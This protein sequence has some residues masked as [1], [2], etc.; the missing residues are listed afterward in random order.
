MV[1]FKVFDIRVTS[2]Q[3]QY[4]FFI[5]GPHYEPDA[6]YCPQLTAIVKQIYC[7]A[8]VYVCTCLP[9][10]TYT[11]DKTICDSLYSVQVLPKCTASKAFLGYNN[12]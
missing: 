2:L 3:F 1:V 7:F 5:D 4:F 12:K 6:R 11:K 8:N 9:E 10:K